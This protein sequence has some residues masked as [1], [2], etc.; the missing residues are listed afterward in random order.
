MSNPQCWEGSSEKPGCVAPT[1]RE[2]IRELER[3]LADY[4]MMLRRLAAYLPEQNSRR[5]QAFALMEQYGDKGRPLRTV[6]EVK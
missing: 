3:Q 4:S 2:Q 6:G 5:K 1:L